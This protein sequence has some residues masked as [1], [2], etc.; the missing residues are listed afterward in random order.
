M[1]RGYVLVDDE[2]D[3]SDEIAVMKQ[4]IKK[5]MIEKLASEWN[6]IHNKIERRQWLEESEDYYDPF[7]DMNEDYVNDAAYEAYDQALKDGKSKEEAREIKAKAKE[8]LW[9]ELERE[10]AVEE[11]KPYLRMEVIEQL[12]SELGARMMRPYEHWNEDERY[13]EYMENRYDNSGW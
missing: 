3:S 8:D 1:T 10:R 13:M 11:N 5:E 9:A 7:V 6:V 2:V 4:S 12:L